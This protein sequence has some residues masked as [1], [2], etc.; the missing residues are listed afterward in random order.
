M[1][2][3]IADTSDE[4]DQIHR[5]NHRTFV[6]EIPQHRPGQLP[7]RRI[8]PFHEHNT[9][10]VCMDRDRLLGMIAVSDH[11]P[12]S[13]DRKLDDLDSHLPRHRSPCE[14]RLLAVV[15]THRQGRVFWALGRELLA[16]CDRRGYDLALISGTTRQR[17][18]YEGLGF[19]AFGPL[20]GSPEAAFRPMYL[21]PSA[22]RSATDAFSR[23]A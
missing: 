6:E 22:L 10:L 18:L 9:Y 21:T 8:D 16:L 17:R 5:L 13:L 20:T 15:P 11:R 14:I 12:F 4:F 23:C 1:R 3:K 7:G 2:V 19:T